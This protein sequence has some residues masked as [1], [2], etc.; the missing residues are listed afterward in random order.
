MKVRLDAVIAEIAGTLD[1]RLLRQDPKFANLWRPHRM[2]LIM[3]SLARCDIARAEKSGG[4]KVLR[5]RPS[6]R[7]KNCVGVKPRGIPDELE[8]IEAPI[9]ISTLADEF[10]EVL[11]ANVETVEEV[12]SYAL[13]LFAMYEMG[14]F[15]YRG[16]KDGLCQFE[17]S[18][19]RVLVEDEAGNTADLVGK[20]LGL[21]SDV[22]IL[23]R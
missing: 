12:A 10:S 9:A 5:W 16:K 18:P 19:Y 6:R 13:R 17:R 3:P 15:E 8:R 7:L 21:D 23:S 2:H 14:L 22:A 11:Q 4:R 1:L 20:Y